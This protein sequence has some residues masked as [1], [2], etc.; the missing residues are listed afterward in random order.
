MS[1]PPMSFAVGDEVVWHD[2]MGVE[3]R[4][5]RTVV[6][7][8]GR[9]RVHLEG[10]DKP[11]SIDLGVRLDGWGYGWVKPVAVFEWEQRTKDAI[12]YLN[13][14]GLRV[15]DY[16]ADMDRLLWAADT[17]RSAPVAPG[18]GGATK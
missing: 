6:A 16:G 14:I 3:T 13:S 8:V 5:K 9:K 15:G 12:K 4:V 17:L 10:D 11:Y 7:R 18:S 2:G 1:R